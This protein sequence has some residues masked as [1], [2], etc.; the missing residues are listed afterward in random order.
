MPR[1]AVKICVVGGGGGG[2]SCGASLVSSHTV[3]SPGS[4][5]LGVPP[6][7]T[8]LQQSRAGCSTYTHLQRSLTG[9]LGV[10]PLHPS[11]LPSF[12]SRHTHSLASW[13][14]CI[15]PVGC[16]GGRRDYTSCNYRDSE[17][18]VA[19][20]RGPQGQRVASRRDNL[21][22]RLQKL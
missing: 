22:P 19:A 13:S 9:C 15:R 6:T 12:H 10:A 17:A 2:G 14:E 16:G 18:V 5:S 20:S 8:H 1:A 21:P 4:R 11:P 7:Y 3:S